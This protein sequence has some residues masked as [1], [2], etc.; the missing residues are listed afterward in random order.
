M[1]YGLS[2]TRIFRESSLLLLEA[3]KSPEEK[4]VAPISGKAFNLP[5]RL[6]KHHQGP[7]ALSSSLV[8]FQLSLGSNCFKLF[9]SFVRTAKLLSL[10]EV[11][12]TPPFPTTTAKPAASRSE[13]KYFGSLHNPFFVVL[14]LILRRVRGLVGQLLRYKD[15]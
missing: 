13:Q 9:S 6:Q 14:N 7:L 2:S 3:V 1:L 10:Y 8:C 4:S 11:L 5:P 15:S 12:V